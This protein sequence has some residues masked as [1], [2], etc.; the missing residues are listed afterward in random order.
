MSEA[1]Q[2]KIKQLVQERAQLEVNFH[3]INGAIAAFESLL[4][5]EPE[6][7]EKTEEVPS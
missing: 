3:R 6:N 7:V 4:K 1:I 2:E 5:D